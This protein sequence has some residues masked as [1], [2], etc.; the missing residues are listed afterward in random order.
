MGDLSKL[1]ASRDAYKDAVAQIY[2]AA[3]TGVKQCRLI[4]KN[5]PFDG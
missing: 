5:L 2:P 3:P 1:A 4:P